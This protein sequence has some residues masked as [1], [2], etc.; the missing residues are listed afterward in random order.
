[1][2]YLWC[3]RTVKQ[4]RNM[5][6]SRFV[7]KHAMDNRAVDLFPWKAT[8]RQEHSDASIS[9]L[10]WNVSHKAFDMCALCSEIVALF[11]QYCV[12][13]STFWNVEVILFTLP[14]K[15]FIES[16]GNEL[17]VILGIDPGFFLI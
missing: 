4:M 3:D 6:E 15:I 2:P 17:V 7:M 5:H 12:L 8:V 16:L 10:L 13:R 14:I 11:W 9:V 1:M